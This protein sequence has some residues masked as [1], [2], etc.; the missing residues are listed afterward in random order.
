MSSFQLNR[1]NSR[2]LFWLTV[3]TAVLGIVTTSCQPNND[4]DLPR[5]FDRPELAAELVRNSTEI[6]GIYGYGRPWQAEFAS[7]LRHSLVANSFFTIAYSILFFY[8]GRTLPRASVISYLVI[9]AA[10]CSAIHN[11]A[12]WRTSYN[13]QIAAPWFFVPALVKFWLLGVIYVVI[14]RVL[15]V[16]ESAKPLDRR[17]LIGTAILLVVGAWRCWLTEST[18]CAVSG[19]LVAMAFVVLSLWR[20]LNDATLD[21]ELDALIAAAGV[22]YLCAGAIT[23]SAVVFANARLEMAVP[24]L[25][26]ALLSQIAVFNITW[27][28]EAH[29]NNGEKNAKRQM[30][31]DTEDHHICSSASGPHW[32]AWIARVGTG[33]P[34][35]SIVFVGETQ[36]EAETRARAF[37]ERQGTPVPRR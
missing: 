3:A 2:T 10:L 33:D 31:P 35:H 7:Q 24:P 37:A 15:L 29:K 36:D 1:N 16:P 28:S 19:S 30:P 17:I 6:A 12:M 4:L 11:V 32:I 27:V 20:V 18:S 26:L 34:D 13:A 25:G 22:G 14:S 5:E 9:P 8:L 21:N 23:L